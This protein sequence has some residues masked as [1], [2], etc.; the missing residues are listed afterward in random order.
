M[1]FIDALHLF[2][3]AADHALPFRV[4]ASCL[5]IDQHQPQVCGHAVPAPFR[6]ILLVGAVPMP[7][8]GMGGP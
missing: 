2:P 8:I 5:Q 7:A 1:F 4:I 6:Q 3:I